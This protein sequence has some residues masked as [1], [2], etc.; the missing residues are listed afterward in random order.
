MLTTIFREVR[1]YVDE[2]PYA[3]GASVGG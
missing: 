2:S 1:D 3:H